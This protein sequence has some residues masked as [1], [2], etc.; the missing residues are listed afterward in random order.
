MLDIEELY[1]NRQFEE[2]LSKIAS[3]N[4]L[5]FDDYRQA[6]FTEI[7]QLQCNTAQECKRSAWRV[8]ERMKTYDM[9]ER[10][11]SFNEHWDSDEDDYASV[12]WEDR[13]VIA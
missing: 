11:Y 4:L 3:K 7:L 5:D 13:H 6:V 1:E 12:L 9:R 2:Y 8:R 10:H